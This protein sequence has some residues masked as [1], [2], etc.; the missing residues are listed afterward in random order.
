MLTLPQSEKFPLSGDLYL[1]IEFKKGTPNVLQCE[2]KATKATKSKDRDQESTEFSSRLLAVIKGTNRETYAID[3]LA[4]DLRALAG[5]A[6][7]E[8]F[9]SLAP[10]V[11]GRER[12][13]IARSRV[14]VYPLRPNLALQNTV[15]LVDGWYLGTNI[16]NR[17]KLK[18]LRVACEL[19]GLQPAPA[20]AV[21]RVN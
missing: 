17:E 14:D 4:Q 11:M 15:R 1:K 9:S 19:K 5:S 20:S 16:A 12:F 21:R 3:A 18:I 8:F 2:F 6:H 7:D 10:K 13:H